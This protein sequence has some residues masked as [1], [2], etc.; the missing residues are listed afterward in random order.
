MIWARRQAHIEVDLSQD[1][2][3]AGR[4]Y[5]GAWLPRGAVWSRVCGRS[6]GRRIVWS[7]VSNSHNTEPTFFPVYQKLPIN[8]SK[9]FNFLSFTTGVLVV[10]CASQTWAKGRPHILDQFLQFSSLSLDPQENLYQVQGC[11]L[12]SLHTARRDGPSFSTF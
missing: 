12:F 5:T 6:Q 1:W 3:L 4:V 11:I 10:I 9:F 7:G 2:Y 8:W